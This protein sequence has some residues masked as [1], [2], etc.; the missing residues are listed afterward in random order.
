MKLC[1]ITAR[2]NQRLRYY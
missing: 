2:P 1:R